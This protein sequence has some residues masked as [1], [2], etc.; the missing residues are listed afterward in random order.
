M[1]HH[2]SGEFDLLQLKYWVQTSLK[3]EKLYKDVHTKVGVTG[4]HVRSCLPQTSVSQGYMEVQN[5]AM[6]VRDMIFLLL[7]FL[8]YSFS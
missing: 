2:G 3:G 6:S 4:D 1:A 7:L 5:E 8:D